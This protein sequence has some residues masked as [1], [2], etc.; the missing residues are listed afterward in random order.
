MLKHAVAV[1]ALLAGIAVAE[2]AEPRLLWARQVQGISQGCAAVSDGQL[3]APILGGS[4]I[5]SMDASTGEVRWTRPLSDSSP[6]PPIV[7]RDSV[8]VITG[9]CTLYRL[10][11]QDGKVMWKVWLA[12]S[13]Q[14]MPTLAGGKVYAAACEKPNHAPRPGGWHLVCLDAAKGKEQWAV[15]IGGDILGAPLVTGPAAYVSTHNGTLWAFDLE[16][17]KVQ[18]KVEAGAQSMPVICREWLV[19]WGPEGLTARNRKDGTTAWTWKSEQPDAARQHA[20]GFRLPM[21]D[22]DRAYVPADANELA[23]IDLA[24]RS[25]AWTWSGGEEQPGG[26][27]MVGGRVYFGTSKGTVVGLN[28]KN[29]KT[30]WAVKTDAMITDMPTIM[31]GKIYF[32]DLKGGVVAVDAATPDA[33]GWG[34]WGGSASHTGATPPSQAPVVV[35]PSASDGEEG[36][37]DR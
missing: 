35:T 1:L 30:L 37:E 21:I 6:F 2:E 20:Y 7:D 25:R 36:D 27:V 19:Y 4:S 12:G 32:H 15:A 5:V 23:C 17:Q 29:G 13:I 9:S 14:S 10:S 31:D 8:Y 34:M 26:P 24:D 22:G 16:Q 28:A 11:R 3:F 18:W 33:T